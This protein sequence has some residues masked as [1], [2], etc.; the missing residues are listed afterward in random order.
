MTRNP[1]GQTNLKE[2]PREPK[3]QRAIVQIDD[4]S[5]DFMFPDGPSSTSTSFH[6]VNNH[7][8]ARAPFADRG[9][10][11]TPQAL[12]VELETQISEED[13]YTDQESADSDTWSTAALQSDEE[14]APNNQRESQYRSC[15]PSPSPPS[16]P[17]F[18]YPNN[19]RHHHEHHETHRQRYDSDLV[20]LS[21]PEEQTSLSVTCVTPSSHWALRIPERYACR[22]SRYFLSH[23]QFYDYDSNLNELLCLRGDSKELDYPWAIACPPERPIVDSD[24]ILEWRRSMAIFRT[25]T[26]SL[27]R[28]MRFE[29]AEEH[30]I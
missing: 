13:Q 18:V 29:N 24:E 6:G 3:E 14:P 27:D 15:S 22:P 10:D 25:R 5:G 1:N 19:T 26:R 21:Q 7:H 30:S 23:Y 8:P 11:T 16:P 12:S 4:F 2:T 28:Y 17:I 20:P 9:S